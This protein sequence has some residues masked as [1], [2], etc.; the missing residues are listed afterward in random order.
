MTL[1]T[2]IKAGNK[3]FFQFELPKISGSLYERRACG[4]HLNLRK[5]NFVP[6]LTCST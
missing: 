6:D 1:G 3:I 4:W 5:G 2:G